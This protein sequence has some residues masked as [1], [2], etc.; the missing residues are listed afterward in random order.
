MLLSSSTVLE[1]IASS[2]QVAGDISRVINN[3]NHAANEIS[4]SSSQVILVF[5]SG[6][7]ETHRLQTN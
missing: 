3:I 5:L 4:D 6:I 2:S 7:V 1:N